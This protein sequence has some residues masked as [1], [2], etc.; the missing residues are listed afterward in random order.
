VV[1]KGVLESGPK[2]AM[3]PKWKEVESPEGPGQRTKVN[4]RNVRQGISSLPMLQRCAREVQEA[5]MR[6]RQIRMKNPNYNAAQRRGR[7][8]RE[9]YEKPDKGHA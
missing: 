1:L 8:G 5:E 3:L 9:K 2:V 4:T 7:E 6:S